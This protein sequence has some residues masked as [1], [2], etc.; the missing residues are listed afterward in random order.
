MVER[1]IYP[2][3]PE[4]VLSMAVRPD[5]KQIALGRYDGALVLLDAITGKVQ[6]Q[7]LPV[8]PKPPKLDKLIPAAGL[9][10]QTLRLRFQGQ[11]LAGEPKII[12]TVPGVKPVQANATKGQIDVEVTIPATTPAGVYQFA[13]ATAAGQT[14]NVPFTVDAF[15][16]VD[17]VE[18]HHSPGT[19]Q[20]VKPPV[21]IVGSVSRAGDVDFYRIE[22]AAG[23]SFG[24]QA[25]TAPLGSK[26]EPILQWLDGDGRLLVESANGLLG[27]TC[28]KAGSTCWAF[29]TAITEAMRRCAIAC[30][31]A[32]WR[33]SP[34]SFR[35]ACS[36]AP[37]RKW[38]WRGSTWGP[39][40]L[41]A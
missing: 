9:R 14:A 32:R 26:L 18:G 19:G 3:Q 29:G 1:M 13:V 31:L 30:T 11:N 15:A 22:A 23:Q 25:L 10:G 7:P 28:P 8:K 12:S 35:S 27:V 34:A 21:T 2:R 37:R 40:A 17:K 6:A 39:P 36:A 16:A 4:A 41:R 33:S 20:G 24:V 5:Q 38:P